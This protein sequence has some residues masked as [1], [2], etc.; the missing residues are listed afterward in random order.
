MP[1]GNLP[2]DIVRLLSFHGPV[3]VWTGTGDKAST[4]KVHLAPFDDEL[5][6]FV[7]PHSSLVEGLLQTCR[8]MVTAKADDKTYTLRLEG[9][10]VAGRPV[11]AHPNRGSITPWLP[12]GMAP[13]RVLAVPFVAES[14]EL[15]RDEGQVRNRYAGP[16]PAGRQSPGAARRLLGAALGGGGR[17]VAISSLVGTFL[18]YGYLGSDYPWRPVAVLL[19]WMASLGLIGG[20]R[21]LGQAA[22]FNKWRRGDG[23]LDD[24]PSLRDGLLAPDEARFMGIV[25]LLCAAIGLAG[26]A[27]L[28]RGS[29]G[30]LVVLI[31]TGAPVLAVSWLLYCAVGSRDGEGG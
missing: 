27:A 3:E 21:L 1:R 29:E 28:P 16:T 14:V 11:T 26:V 17:W 4:D 25:G 12:E 24:L 22:A 8:T 23:T 6:L 20:I 10:A 13:S 19:A 9:H 31:T 5:I 15:I 7:P 2:D 18:W 30:V